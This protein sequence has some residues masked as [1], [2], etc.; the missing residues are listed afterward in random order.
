MTFYSYLGELNVHVIDCSGRVDEEMGTARLSAL[1]HEL[2]AHPMQGKPRRMLIDFRNTVWANEEAHRRLGA[3][4]R[5]G[6]GLG[7]AHSALRVAILHGLRHGSVSENEHWFC[8]EFEALEWLCPSSGAR[9]G[10]VP[11]E[12]VTPRLRL[13]LGTRRLAEAALEGNSGLSAL[14]GADVPAAWPPETLRPA[15]PIFLARSKQ[16]GHFEPWG[17]G[18]YGVLQADAGAVLCGS[19]GFKGVPTLA[20]MVE[21]GYSVLPSFQRLGVATEMV[22]FAA[23][24]ALAQPAVCCV[25]AEVSLENVASARVLA[26]AGFV[27]HGAGTTGTRRFRL[28]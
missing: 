18:W 8:S 19:V 15:L 20:G 17:L 9:S 25:E 3:I 1:E 24:W 11:L 7:R 16:T 12:V 6:L 22:T 10:P 5:E 27:P 21:I 26:K 14:L 23:G 4:A 13:V 2:E 28:G